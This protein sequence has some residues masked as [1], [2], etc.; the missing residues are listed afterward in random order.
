M[1]S[2]TRIKVCGITSAEDAKEAIEAGVDAVGFIFAE[3][4]PRY[5]SPEKVKEIVAQLPPFIHYVGVFVDKDPIEIEEIIEYCGLSYVQLHGSEDAEYCRKLAQ[6]ATPCKVIKAFRVSSRTLASDFTPY[7]ETVKGFLLDTHVEGQEG[8]TGKPFDWSIIQSLKLQ[9]PMILAGGLTPENAAEA[10]RAVRPF[11][12]DVNSGVEDEPGKK[13]YE[14][15][16]RL[17][18]N[19]AAADADF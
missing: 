4:S 5:I 16:R 2:R 12:I 11:A 8:G 18:K 19:V 15:L 1:H 17:V 10:V 14:K 9:L 3:K 7:E 6:A 13:N